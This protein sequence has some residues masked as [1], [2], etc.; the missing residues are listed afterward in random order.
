[1]GFTAGTSS[2]IKVWLR[3]PHRFRAAL[4]R[5]KPAGVQREAGIRN[6]KSRNKFWRVQPNADARPVPVAMVD[7]IFTT[8]G[9]FGHFTWLRW[10][11]G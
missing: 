3:R 6:E 1:M 8:A 7:A 4:P 9:R 10:R 5:R 11:R 2:W